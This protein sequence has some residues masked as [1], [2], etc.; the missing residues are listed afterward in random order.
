MRHLPLLAAAS[1]IALAACSPKVEVA[2]RDH[3]P[4]GKHEPLRAISRLDCPDRQGE[5]TRVSAAAD[6]QA[7]VYA[8]QNAEV[9]LKLVA[10]NGGDAERS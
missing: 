6:G 3:K 5:L 1:L 4:H 7:C 10:L 9:A 8:G 2:H